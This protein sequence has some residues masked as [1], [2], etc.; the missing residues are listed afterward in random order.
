MIGEATLVPPSCSQPW[1]VRA[2]NTLSYT[3]PTNLK[4]RG[5][6]DV[7]SVV[8]DGLKGLPNGVSAV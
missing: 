8:C 2:G 7:Y 6:R 4:N 5:I 1:P 3:D